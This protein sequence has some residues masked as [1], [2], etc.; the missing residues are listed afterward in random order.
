MHV[1][2]RIVWPP[3]MTLLVSLEL[4]SLPVKSRFLHNEL[5]Y[6]NVTVQGT[7]LYINPDYHI[8]YENIENWESY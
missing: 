1:L 4:K 7:S 6:C 3:F 5:R 2:N 8:S